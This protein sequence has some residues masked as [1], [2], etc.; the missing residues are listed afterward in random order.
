MCFTNSKVEVIF[1]LGM[2]KRTNNLIYIV[3]FSRKHIYFMNIF[4]NIHFALFRQIP[5][6]QNF[7]SDSLFA[8]IIYYRILFVT[9]Y[10]G[11]TCMDARIR[12]NAC[13]YACISRYI[14]L[15]KW[16][17]HMLTL[18]ESCR[19]IT[20]CSGGVQYT[21]GITRSFYAYMHIVC[22]RGRTDVERNGDHRSWDAGCKHLLVTIG[23]YG[24]S[25]GESMYWCW[26]FNFFKYK[27]SYR[28]RCHYEHLWPVH[29]NDTQLDTNKVKRCY[30][31][32]QCIEHI[33]HIESHC[34]RKNY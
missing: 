20:S 26:A 18:P 4:L 34:D 6:S 2:Y 19:R 16:A 12:R 33:W 24:L 23:L 21:L 9:R 22:A 1:D 13:A 11:C 7:P 32:G 31:L 10:C 5:Q 8:L 27:E 25:P 15:I 14:N 30:S 3:G 28:Q 29:V 17:M